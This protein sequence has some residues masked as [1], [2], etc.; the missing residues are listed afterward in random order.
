[1]KKNSF[2]FIAMISWTVVLIF[3]LS[4]LVYGLSRSRYSYDVPSYDTTTTTWIK[5]DEAFLI[6]EE[7]FSIDDLTSL[8]FKSTFESL[9]VNVTDTDDIVVLQYSDPGLDKEFKS[10]IDNGNLNISLPGRDHL[11]NF[12]DSSFDF[13]LEIY[14]PEKYANA[15]SFTSSSGSINIFGNPVW[16]D[17]SVTS[18]SGSIDINTIYCKSFTAESSS[19]SIYI[20]S[21]ECDNNANI[22]T[23]SGS[24]NI[25][26]LIAL[27]LDIQMSS[28]SLDGQDIIVDK[29]LDLSSKSGAIQFNSIICDEFNVKTTSGV[30]ST[31]EIIGSGHIDSSSGSININGFTILGDTDISSKTGS[32]YVLTTP[33]QN[34]K[35]N[36]QTNSGGIQCT[37]PVDY[38]NDRKSKASGTVGDGSIGTLSVFASSGSINID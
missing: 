38:E 14:I 3:L 7:V 9:I 8:N 30:F 31:N 24:I 1:M 26:Q 10:S 19:G 15:A 2:T 20:Y 5:N 22:K 36:L 12:F 4:I 32:I 28:G 21:I 33:S 18:S 11:N 6:K 16:S 13:R 27:N 23:S 29:N 35:I 37:F 17:A 25:N 34:Y